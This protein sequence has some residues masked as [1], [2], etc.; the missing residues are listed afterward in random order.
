[1]N[2]INS[3]P[4]QSRQQV[5]HL[6]KTSSSYADKVKHSKKEILHSVFSPEKQSTASFPKNPIHSLQKNN[7]VKQPEWKYWV[8]KSEDNLEEDFNNLWVLNGLF[9]FDDWKE[10]VLYLEDLFQVKIRINPFF[11]RQSHLQNYSRRV[12]RSNW[13]NG[14][15]MENF[16]CYSKNGMKP[17][18]ADQ[19]ILKA[20][21]DGCQSKIFLLIYGEEISLKQLKPTLVD[22]KV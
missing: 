1:M 13:T 15:T 17:N 5:S 14:S 6:P 2:Y 8:R 21:E 11:C 7:S 19:L 10:I 3:E 16:I 18:T 12:W 22:W 20:L 4:D 9:F